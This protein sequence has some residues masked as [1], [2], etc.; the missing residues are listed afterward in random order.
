MSCTSAIVGGKF[1]GTVHAVRHVPPAELPQDHEPEPRHGRIPEGLR[2]CATRPRNGRAR[3]STTTRRRKFPLTG[4]HV[5]VTCNQCHVGGDYA[6]TVHAV[7]LVPPADLSEDHQP[8]PRGGRLPEG[9]RRL[10]HDHA[11]EGGDVRSQHETKFPL[12]GAHCRCVQPVPR[13]R[14]VH[15][16]CRRSACG[17][18][19]PDY[20]K[21]T[22][23]NHVTAGFPQDCTAC[24]T[25]TQWT[26]RHVR[27]HH[28]DE[29]PADRS[30]RAASRAASA[31][32]AGKYTGTAAQCAACHLPNFQKTT[33]PN[34]VAA[35]IPAGL[36]RVPHHH[37]VD[38]RQVRS[39]QDAVPPDRGA[40]A[41][42][43]HAVPRRGKSTRAPPPSASAA[44]C[45]I[46]RRPPI[47]TTSRPASRRTAPPAT[48]RRNGKAPRSTTARRRSSR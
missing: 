36:R 10:P 17:C 4:A 5:P 48:R 27:P 39:Q 12:T 40:H 26:G 3:S 25:T 47:R 45:R 44:T 46:T 29:V 19:L 9:L 35:G 21:T 33:N 6:G 7:R 13:G 23:P 8:E 42:P 43:V 1:A 34:H 16:T 2:R 11:M 38:G 32:S 14:Q 24:H 30:A 22:N 20:Q 18:H 28:D 15:G 37:A 41:G 31:T